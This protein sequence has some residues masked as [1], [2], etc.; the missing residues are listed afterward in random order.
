MKNTPTF[1]CKNIGYNCT[2]ETS[3]TSL[4]T[5]IAE[6]NKHVQE[7]HD[8]KEIPPEHIKEIRERWA[9]QTHTK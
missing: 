2:F 7:A 1:K 5:V 4:D 6:A 3:S 9:A 8:I